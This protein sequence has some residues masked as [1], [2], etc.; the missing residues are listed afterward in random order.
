MSVEC[1]KYEF[2]YHS[3]CE[4][5]ERDPFLSISTYGD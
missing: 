5:C 3:L 4:E 2:C 1:K